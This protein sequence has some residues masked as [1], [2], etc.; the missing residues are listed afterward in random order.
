V[1]HSVE[2][3]LNEIVAYGK[4]L[5]AESAMVRAA[6]NRLRE[7]LESELQNVAGGTPTLRTESEAQRDR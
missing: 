2:A 1:I 3:S 4:P 6:F 5:T 7:M